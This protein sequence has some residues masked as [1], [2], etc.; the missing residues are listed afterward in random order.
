MYN[1]KLV[2]AIILAAGSSQRFKHKL[3]SNNKN[4]YKINN[5]EIFKYSL[6]IFQNNN[7][8]DNIILVTQKDEIDLFKSSID[9][10]N[11]LFVNGGNSRKQSVF[12]AISK[13]KDGIVLIHDGARPLITDENIN[14]LLFTMNKY[15]GS[16]LAVKS[17]DTIKISDEN[18]IVLSTTNREFT[19]LIQ[20]PQCFDLKTLLDAHIK[21]KEDITVTDDCSL[22]EK[23]NEPIKLI[24]GSYKN[25]K[26][27]TPE[28]IVIAT[29]FINTN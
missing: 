6:E 10:A 26:I 9:T 22:L 12:N 29:A 27:T 5:K 17:K 13:V 24:N 8:I 4:L 16:T 23:I 21:F 14:D 20:T 28:D 2:T 1:N 11:I 25:I 18:N 7:Y 15:K 3:Y 19:W